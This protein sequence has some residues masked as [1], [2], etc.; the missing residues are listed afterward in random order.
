[1]QEITNDINE[2][3]LFINLSQIEDFKKYWSIFKSINKNSNATIVYI[4]IA[5]LACLILFLN[6]I[7]PNKDTDSNTLYVNFLLIIIF[8][9][10]AR[11][12]IIKYKAQKMYIQQSKFLNRQMKICFYE[13]YYTKETAQSFRKM[14]YNEISNIVAKEDLYCILQYAIYVIVDKNGF[15]DST[16]EQF[17]SFIMQR[18]SQNKIKIVK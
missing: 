16:P 10:I 8:V 12:L 6:I 13:N 14:Y 7:E 5:V 2:Q 4:C 18:V 3:P 11:P 9:I 17:E 15:I 1:M